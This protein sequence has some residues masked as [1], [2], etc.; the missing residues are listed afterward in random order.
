VSLI[1]DEIDTLTQET[2]TH[3][4]DGFVE[5][6]LSIGEKN[7]YTSKVFL[8]WKSSARNLFSL[9]CTGPGGS[10]FV[11]W[12]DKESVPVPVTLARPSSVRKG[13]R[14]FELGD[15][16]ACD[17][18]WFLIC[19]NRHSSFSHCPLDQKNLQT[20]PGTDSEVKLCVG[21]CALVRWSV[22]VPTPGAL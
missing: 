14:I 17:V 6:A 5:I 7:A 22:L 11:G 16:D 10:G 19:L 4:H 18:D 12:R 15:K 20:P 1:V 13:R 8:K 2:E 9:C 21:K 3:T